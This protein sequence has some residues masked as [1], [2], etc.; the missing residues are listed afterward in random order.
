MTVA[1]VGSRAKFVCSVDGAV[2]EVV[3]TWF[4]ERLELHDGPK[5]FINSLVSIYKSI[6]ILRLY[7]ILLTVMLFFVGYQ[8]NGLKSQLELMVGDN[9]NYVYW[10]S[11]EDMKSKIKRKTNFTLVTTGK[12]IL[13]H[14]TCF[15]CLFHWHL[16]H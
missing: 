13:Y 16:A 1:E 2:G 14:C 15:C 5:Y 4:E 10:C 3:F 8:D 9:E 6:I 7:I 12:N 11:A